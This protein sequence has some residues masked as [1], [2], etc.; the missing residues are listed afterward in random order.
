MSKQ[1][2]PMEGNSLSDMIIFANCRQEKPTKDE[3]EAF[4]ELVAF[5]GKW[6]KKHKTLVIK[7]RLEMWPEIEAENTWRMTITQCRPEKG[8]SNE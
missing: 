3:V 8:G 7:K 1:N 2:T 4:E 6:R 5:I